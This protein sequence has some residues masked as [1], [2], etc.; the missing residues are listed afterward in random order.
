MLAK[1]YP[2]LEKPVNCTKK[3]SLLES[4][5]LYQMHRN[6]AKVDERMLLEQMKLDVR[7]ECRA[8][9]CEETKNVVLDLIAQGFT[10]EEIKLHLE[11]N[12]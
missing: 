2:E 6:L 9:G 4:I 5:R 12:R 8:E 1:K 11:K 3:M 7:E 10:T